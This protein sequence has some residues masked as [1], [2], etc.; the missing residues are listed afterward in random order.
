MENVGKVQNKGIELSLN[1]T[2]IQTRDFNWQTDFNISF[3]RNKVKSLQEG[4]SEILSATKFNTNF[5]DTTM[6]HM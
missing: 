3:V 5:K 1:T 4:A 6:S 2:N